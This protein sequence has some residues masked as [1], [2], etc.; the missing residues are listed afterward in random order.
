MTLIQCTFL[1]CSEG[2]SKEGG[3]GKKICWTLSS[4]MVCVMRGSNQRGHYNY[5]HIE[6]ISDVCMRWVRANCRNDPQPC[7]H[8]PEKGEIPPSHWSSALNARLW[9][10][11]QREGDRRV[12]VIMFAILCQEPCN[13]GAMR[14]LRGKENS[15]TCWISRIKV[16]ILTSQY[17][18]LVLKSC[19]LYLWKQ[20]LFPL[21]AM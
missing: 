13:Y 17:V 20:T 3:G 9:L 14:G 15:T 19:H 21:K 6:S 7:L 10:V 18:S 12:P 16:Q 1:Y 5:Y 8:K 11:G 2:R 4:D